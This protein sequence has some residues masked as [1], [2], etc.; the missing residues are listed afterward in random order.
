VTATLNSA[1]NNFFSACL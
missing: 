1:C